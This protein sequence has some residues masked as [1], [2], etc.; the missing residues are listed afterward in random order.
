MRSVDLC[1]YCTYLVTMLEL[2][3]GIYYLE[4]MSDMHKQVIARSVSAAEATGYVLGYHMCRTDLPS[5]TLMF[6]VKASIP[7]DICLVKSRLLF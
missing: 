4:G 2:L 7:S 6:M 3:C 1:K 5:L